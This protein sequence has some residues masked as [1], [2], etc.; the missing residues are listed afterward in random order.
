MNI[1]KKIKLAVFFCS[2]G[3][4]FSQNI[5][6]QSTE[7]TKNIDVVSENE[8]E[9]NNVLN[10]EKK[11]KQQEEI[12]EIIKDLSS[13]MQSKIKDIDEIISKTKTKEEFENYPAIR[14]NIDTPFFGLKS[15]VDQKMKITKDVATVDV[16]NGYSIKDIIKTSKIKVPDISVANIVVSTRDVK[17]D[18]DID[19]KDGNLA[20]FKLMQYIS[21]LNNTKY[22]LESGI[23]KTF[24]EYI[25]KE[26]KEKITELHQ[27]LDKINS[28]L[29]EKSDALVQIYIISNNEE[30]YNNY[31]KNYLEYNNQIS[32]ISNSLDNILITEEELEIATRNVINL[33]AKMLDYSKE[34]LST[35]NQN[36]E[37][38]DHQKM[39]LNIKKDLEK[40]KNNIQEYISNS[41]V[42][43]NIEIENKQ[44]DNQNEEQVQNET[45]TKDTINTTEEIKV[46][47]VLSKNILE[48]LNANI[49]LIDEYLKKYVDPS[50]YINDEELNKKISSEVVN[51]TQVTNVIIEE[52][53][54]EKKI[55]ILNEISNIYKDSVSKENK[56]YLDNLNYMIK[57][58]TM[59]IS[60]IVKNTDENILK[61]I[62]YI[63]LELPISL[64][65]YF[66]YN[67]TSATI[68]KE[69]LTSL[70]ESELTK[71]LNSNIDIT[72]KYTKMLEENAKL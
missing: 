11:A 71:L 52:V 31:L 72:K 48:N 30:A 64:D 54:N 14:L 35:Y 50:M 65:E 25:P 34:V 5:Y 22:F 68:Q 53:T 18:K 13:Q 24:S 60:Q 32:D 43:K 21:Q 49:N 12:Y 51:K 36:K 16:A 38:I 40:R 23:N 27:R 56:F 46:Y 10:D 70:L 57:D 59:K 4:L 1:F 63:Y 69:K 33:E 61:D 26:K 62:K 41:T 17:L 8:V 6:A 19:V 47:E 15:I 55:E 42:D 58:T 67:N 9:D 44:V 45:N 37:N 29:T 39:I 3:I 66:K 7:E 20:V 28:S 2:L